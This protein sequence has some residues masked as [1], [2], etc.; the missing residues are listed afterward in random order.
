MPF[1]AG[2]AKWGGVESTGLMG[3]ADAV[4]IRAAPDVG[5]RLIAKRTHRV[6]TLE[7]LIANGHPSV[8]EHQAA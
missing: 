6:P 7:V 1:V 2:G 5:E 8:G 3:G 4:E